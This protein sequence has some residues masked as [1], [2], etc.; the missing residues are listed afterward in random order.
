MKCTQGKIIR[1]MTNQGDIEIGNYTGK[2]S[3]VVLSIR[4][5]KLKFEREMKPTFT[6][7]NSMTAWVRGFS[8]FNQKF[9]YS[10]SFMNR[11]RVFRDRKNANV[12]NT[13]PDLPSR[14][15]KKLGRDRFLFWPHEMRGV[16]RNMKKKSAIVWLRVN[17]TI[18]LIPGVETIV[19]FNSVLKMT[20]RHFAE[21]CLID[22]TS[23]YQYKQPKHHRYK[24][25][26]CVCWSSI[27]FLV[28]VRGEKNV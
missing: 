15:L 17:P 27:L 25:K 9:L 1:C 7:E 21:N 16:W 8:Y 24:C 12:S 2:N 11:L 13:L 10:T 19:T 28:S 3:L 22:Y 5:P 20:R 4:M 18:K 6:H 23:K 14:I 26:T